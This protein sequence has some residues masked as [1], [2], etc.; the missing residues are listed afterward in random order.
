MRFGVG[1]GNS[2]SR[3]SRA[4]LVAGAVMAPI[5]VAACSPTI[6]LE[7]VRIPDESK[8]I[9]T[10]LPSGTGLV[11]PSV[12]VLV[13]AQAGRLAQ[14]AVTGPKGPLPGRMSVDGT[15]WQADSTALGYGTT[16]QVNAT[17]VDA[18]GVQT[19]TTS[20]F[21]TVEPEKFFDGKVVSPAAGSIVGVGTPI[22]IDFDRSIKNKAE[23]EKAL[24]ISTPTAIEGAWAWRDNS[25]VEFRPKE[26]WPGNIGVTVS[27]NLHGVQSAKNV[28]GEDDH[29]MSFSFGPSTVTKVD[30]LTHQAEV[31]RDGVSIRTI[32]V[33]TG[34][35][36]FETRSGTLLIASK[37]RNRTM[38]A[39]TGGTDVNDPEYYRIDVE[40]AMRI[41]WSGEFLHAAP[42]SVG[43]QGRANVSHG[44]IGMST[45]NA[46]WLYDESM[47]GDVVEITGTSVPQN[48][49]NGITVWTETWAQ[50]LARSSAGVVFTT[51][52]QAPVA[53]I[54]GTPNT[55]TPS[56]TATPT[57][58]QS[59]SPS[60]TGSAQ[61][62]SFS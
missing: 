53:D 45:A 22:I 3:P 12:P 61:P 10:A 2:S 7:T 48:L 40:Y 25:T 30:A 24:V 59:P 39:A 26:Y 54:A 49:G 1:A 37:E 46:Q 20:E 13:T 8:A 29:T 15:S 36:G 50:W 5:L 19:S 11:K 33:T 38:D 57:A 52:T 35:L 28:Y 41:S 56:A 27:M 32:P 44:C 58:P 14:V 6:S 4:L 62:V 16:Y 34:K 42:W 55:G 51:A 21:S 31:I 47:I 9:I 23:V 60:P 17:A 18:R 43:S